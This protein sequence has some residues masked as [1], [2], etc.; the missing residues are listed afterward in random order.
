MS[1]VTKR[2]RG[3]AKVCVIAWVSV[4]LSVS[5]CIP[6]EAASTGKVEGSVT[7]KEGEKIVGAR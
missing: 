7:G 4:I 1:L 6:Q 2:V 3:T 5:Y